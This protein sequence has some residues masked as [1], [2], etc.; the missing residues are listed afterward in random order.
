MAL[1]NQKLFIHA[2]SGG[3]G[4]VFMLLPC[5]IKILNSHNVKV[6]IILSYPAL[7]EVF[8]FF[9]GEDIGQVSFDIL[10]ADRKLGLGL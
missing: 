4:D 8:R 2:S 7:I 5:L 1:D 6:K 10:P 9:L 3:L